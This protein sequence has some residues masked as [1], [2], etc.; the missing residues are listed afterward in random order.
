MADH[1]GSL[2]GVFAER[3]RIERELGHGGM[4]TVYLATD[5]KHDRT[6]AIKVLSAGVTHSLGAERFLREIAYAA[7][8]V[9]P[10]ILPLHDSGH[11]G[12]VLYYVMPF[13]DGE[14]LRARLDRETQL[15]IDDALQI[16]HAV[17]DALGYAHRIG[18][19]HRDIKP[20]NILLE[21][22]HAC[23]ADFG[24][25][26][27]VDQ[28][29]EEQLT[30]TGLAI[31]T[32]AYMSPEQ[33]SGSKNLD[34]RSDVYSLACV[35]YEML[36]GQPPFLG[37]SV[38]S[39]VRQHNTAPPPRI[40]IIRPAVP[41]Y[42]AEA[43]SRGLAKTPADRCGSAAQFRDALR[44]SA[45]KHAETVPSRSR[46]LRA[47]SVLV[48]AGLAV[49][50]PLAWIAFQSMSP[51]DPSSSIASQPPP[52]T[53][54]AK[55]TGS[56]DDTMRLVVGRLAESFLEGSGVV[57]PLPDDQIRR[58]LSYAGYAD[59][60]TVTDELAKEL[61][62][63]GSIRTI[64]TGNVDRIGRT[65]AISVRVHDVDSS[66]TL[67]SARTA[68]NSESELVPVLERT[69]ETLVTTLRE[70]A[71]AFRPLGSTRPVQTPSF[72]AFKKLVAASRV[73]FIDPPLARGL[74]REALALDPEFAAAW[75][76][77]AI[78]SQ[79]W[80]DSAE[81][82]L[83]EALRH[84]HRLG[85]AGGL[86]IE[87]AIA[88]LR[89]DLPTAVD[90][91]ERALM[92]DPGH[93]AA[94]V[95]R[96]ASLQ[97][98]GRFGEAAECEDE[99]ERRSPFGRNP[100][101]LRNHVNSLIGAGRLDDAR[102]V[103]DQLTEPRRYRR[104]IELK[105]ASADGDW[106]RAESL[107]KAYLEDPTSRLW[108]H[109]RSRLALGSVYAARGAVRQADSL[110]NH[111]AMVQPLGVAISRA[112]LIT[113]TGL[114]VPEAHSDLT[115]TLY[116]RHLWQAVRDYAWGDTAQARSSMRSLLKESFLTPD[117]RW[118][119]YHQDHIRLGKALMSAHEGDWETTRQLARAQLDSWP[120]AEIHLFARWLLATSYEHLGQRDSAVTYFKQTITSSGLE[121]H[122]LSQFGIPWSF[123]HQ[124]LVIL[125]SALGRVEEA[126]RHWNI[127]RDAFTAPDPEYVHLIEEAR[128]ALETAERKLG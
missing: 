12:D 110:L 30:G 54:V 116:T 89:D 98:M 109:G 44:L 27:A 40:T 7:R 48:I 106:P 128:Q 3:Y 43:I 16:A 90:R 9:H 50:S 64:V 122:E 99:Y 100:N 70:T 96:C 32:P 21:A 72:A 74:L 24:I 71:V 61:A 81:L 19:V 22:G 126:R 57:A 23:V 29:G 52:F 78:Q 102:R 66:R 15:P 91:F 125:Y 93:R 10:H 97:N 39:L 42:V 84:P 63:R 101:R 95:N 121:A 123:A 4:A 59:T 25:A 87:G 31:G 69:V 92:L 94:F 80:S 114:T 103:A 73:G 11:V 76:Y 120:G 20:E 55:F 104:Y 115:D 65:Y 111:D 41:E 68:A 49:L 75:Y 67:A 117:R 56:A 46:P 77:L 14:S 113:V 13:V 118:Q 105:L 53:I 58:G 51:D 82:F 86:E 5:L 108:V 38:E 33:A 35:L 124:R 107:A 45:R 127:F 79:E 34:G 83:K 112:L 47:R 36:A 85:E 18:I 28:S 17:A 8:L 62:I 119:R 88:F 60:T 37:A 26:R 1:I 6:V 2:T